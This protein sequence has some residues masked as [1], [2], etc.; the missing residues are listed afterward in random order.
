MVS[1]GTD[2]LA[3]ACRGVACNDRDGVDEACELQTH[4]LRKGSDKK[5]ASWAAVDANLHDADIRVDAQGK[6]MRQ[7]DGH[8]AMLH[9]DP[10]MGVADTLPKLVVVAKEKVDGILE[11]S[12][13]RQKRTTKERNLRGEPRGCRRRLVAAVVFRVCLELVKLGLADR[14]CAKIFR[15]LSELAKEV[16]GDGHC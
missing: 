14:H 6:D 2:S 13:V 10:R 11:G 9:A 1:G 8:S 7:L 16:L 12:L 4:H 5:V 15:V 3:V